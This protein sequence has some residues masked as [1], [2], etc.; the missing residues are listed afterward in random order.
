MSSI[1]TLIQK[2]YAMLTR[3]DASG[4]AA[5]DRIVR[6]ITLVR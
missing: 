4:R 2:T 5:G 3:T 6:E 1:V